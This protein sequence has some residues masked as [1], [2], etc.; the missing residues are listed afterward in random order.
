MFPSVSSLLPAFATVASSTVQPRQSLVPNVPVESESTGDTFQ[1]NTATPPIQPQP[2][3][4]GRIIVPLT[5]EQADRFLQIGLKEEAAY[6][7]TVTADIIT[8]HKDSPRQWVGKLIEKVQQEPDIEEL[9][10]L[11]VLTN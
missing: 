3:A 9:Q 7:A 1:K 5:T 11:R 4:G 2:K 8:K 10:L 6:W